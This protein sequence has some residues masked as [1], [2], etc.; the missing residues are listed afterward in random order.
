MSLKG[1]RRGRHSGWWLVHVD[2]YNNNIKYIK[3]FFFLIILCCPLSLFLEDI[4]DLRGKVPLYW[5]RRIQ[6]ERRDNH[7]NGCLCQQSGGHP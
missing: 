3:S 7:L 5:S 4:Q 1:E 2:L 6:E